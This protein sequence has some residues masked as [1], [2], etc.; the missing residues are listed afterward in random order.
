MRRLA[1]RL[2]HLSSL[3]HPP[4]PIERASGRA[5]I[6]QKRLHAVL[7]DRASYSYALEYQ[8][9]LRDATVKVKQEEGPG[10]TVDSLILLEH[11][12]VYTLGRNANKDNVLFDI[13]A[14][15]FELFHSDRGGEV[16]YHGDGQLVG[17]LIFDLEN[18]RKDL[19]WFLREIEETVI[20]VLAQLGVEA[21]RHEEYTGV[22]VGDGKIA[23][24]G[25]SASRWVSMHGFSINLDPDLGAFSRII[26]CG[27]D[28]PE[29]SVTSVKK[30][31]EEA[32][33]IDR[34]VRLVWL[35]K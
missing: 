12:P 22:W 30:L 25:L 27:I 5:V 33:Q 29:K 32:D 2:R 34:Y 4:A 3:P 24:I 31:K 21:E 17:Y 19:H 14:G 7:H 15:E 13:S 11:D 1:S 35:Q 8:R 6:P 9:S 10:A 18:H 26:P 20:S 28:D 16:T 23:A